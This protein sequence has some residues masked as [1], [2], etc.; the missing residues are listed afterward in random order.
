[1]YLVAATAKMEHCSYQRRCYK[2]EHSNGLYRRAKVQSN[3]DWCLK[4]G[5]KAWHWG[6]SYEEAL[7]KEQRCAGGNTIKFA[8]IFRLPCLIV[9]EEM[10]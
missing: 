8:D 3:A 1:M 4:V 5:D 6:W 2:M 9:P 10:L 7:A